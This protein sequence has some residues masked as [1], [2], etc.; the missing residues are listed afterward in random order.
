MSVPSYVN[1][2]ARASHVTNNF[3]CIH[4]RTRR[5]IKISNILRIVRI[6]NIRLGLNFGIDFK[7]VSTEL[8]PPE[9]EEV[10]DDNKKSRKRKY[11]LL[12]KV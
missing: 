10:K 11:S 4:R 9:K 7:F 3:K 8:S 5:K 6:K 2:V 1:S 12:Y